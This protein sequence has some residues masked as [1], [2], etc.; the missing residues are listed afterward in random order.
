MIVFVFGVG[1]IFYDLGAPDLI[2]YVINVDA[3]QPTDRDRA[4]VHRAK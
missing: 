4:V 2:P 3:F 1:K